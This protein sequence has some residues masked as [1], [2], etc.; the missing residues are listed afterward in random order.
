MNKWVVVAVKRICNEFDGILDNK[1]YNSWAS[2]SVA[3]MVALD[4]DAKDET[5]AKKY[6]YHIICLECS[7]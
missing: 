2:A 7:E 1:Y 6:Y 3:R 4:E 5:L